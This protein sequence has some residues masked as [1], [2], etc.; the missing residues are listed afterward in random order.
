MPLLSSTLETR[1]CSRRFGAP[2]YTVAT[3]YAKFICKFSIVAG[4][5]RSMEPANLLASVTSGL[6]YRL[7]GRISVAGDY[8]PTFSKDVAPSSAVGSMSSGSS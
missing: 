1:L 2:P 6:I 8:L 3:L 7:W 5:D 4:V